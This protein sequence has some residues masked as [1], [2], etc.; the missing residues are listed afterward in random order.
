[1]CYLVDTYCVVG[2]VN[3]VCDLLAA[4]FIAPRRYNWRKDT[5]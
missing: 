5:L 4:C 1:M 2:R 3:S